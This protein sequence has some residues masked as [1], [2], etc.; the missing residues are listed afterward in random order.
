MIVQLICGC[1]VTVKSGAT[2]GRCMKHYSRGPQDIIVEQR[3]EWH[4]YC[5][6]KPCKASRWLGQSKELAEQWADRH[7]AY[8]PLHADRVGVEYVD[9]LRKEDTRSI[10]F[11][12][13]AMEPLPF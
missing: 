10:V 2:M 1:F 8:N 9:R 11:V 4:A 5:A 13:Q 3:E 7:A 6:A 12:H